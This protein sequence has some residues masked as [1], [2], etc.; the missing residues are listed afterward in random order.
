MRLVC[1]INNLAKPKQEGTM[2][3]IRKRTRHCAPYGHRAEYIQVSYFPY[4]GR[5]MP[6]GRARK[7]EMSTPKQKR[8]NNKNSRRK[9]EA[10]V[11]ANFGKGDYMLSPNYNPENEPQSI[12]EA[13]RQV[14]NYIKRLNYAAGKRGL[15]KVKALWV[16]EQG[17]KSGRIH[18]H[19]LI[20]TELP[21]ELLEEKWGKGYCNA[22]RLQM[23]RKNALEGIAQ[24][25]MKSPKGNRR[26][27]GTHNLVNPWE[28]TNDN[29]R[30][31]SA[32]KME[33]LKQ[34]PE[35]SERARAIIEGDNPG[36]TLTSLE[37][38]FREDIGQWYF[39]ARMELKPKERLNENDSGKL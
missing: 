19:I 10:I 26:W 9:F 39:F 4:T 38:E 7:Q 6:K 18:H 16:T 34:I 15:P 13:Q 5:P 23:T 3:K 29:P 24:Y 28:S 2:G 32:R 36:Y 37:K 30:M 22:D 20:K 27:N 31:M 35:D 14:Y 12:E 25:M 8:L 1:G 11:K 33:T 21:R 17:T